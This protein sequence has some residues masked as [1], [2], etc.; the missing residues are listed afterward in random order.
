MIGSG[1]ANQ[2]AVENVHSHAERRDSRSDSMM[3]FRMSCSEHVCTLT[4]CVVKRLNVA[5]DADTHLVTVS[6]VNEKLLHDCGDAVLLYSPW[7]RFVPC[8]RVELKRLCEIFTRMFADPH[9]KV[10]TM[11]CTNP[12]M[13]CV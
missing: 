8:S 6:V 7:C 4:L 1:L 10:E 3:L 13:T 5:G 11:T 2:M 9:S 12:S